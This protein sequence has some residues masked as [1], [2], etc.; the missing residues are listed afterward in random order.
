MAAPHLP[1]CNAPQRTEAAASN[2]RCLAELW[3]LFCANSHARDHHGVGKA[4]DYCAPPPTPLQPPPV[5]PKPDITKS[6]DPNSVAVGEQVGMG[7]EA[8]E[9]F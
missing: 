7:R 9:G 8:H 4:P 3:C 1:S 2:G 6:A 5:G